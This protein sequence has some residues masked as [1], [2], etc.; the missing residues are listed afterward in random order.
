[1]EEV[2]TNACEFDVQ[3]L[4]MSGK[5]LLDSLDLD[6]LLKVKNDLPADATGPQVFAAVIGQHQSLNTS[7]VRILTEQL[8]KLHLS[9]EPAED[10]EAFSQKVLDIAKRIRGAGPKTCPADLPT[11]VYECYQHCSTQQFSLDVSSLLSKANKGDAMVSDWET[12]ISTLKGTYHAL[13]SRSQ[14][15]AKKHHKEK[16]EI[17]ALQAMIKTLQK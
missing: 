13:I 9:K 6:M 7:A 14:W 1:V 3:N 5:M 8:Q 10:V 17:Q 4:T 15:N 16:V 11:L 2:R 12:E